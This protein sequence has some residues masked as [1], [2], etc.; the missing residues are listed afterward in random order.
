MSIIVSS[1]DIKTLERLRVI[2]QIAPMREKMRSFERKYGCE[3]QEFE[4]SIKLRPESFEAW[5]DL[6]EWKAYDQALKDLE[7]KLKRIEDAVNVGIAP[8]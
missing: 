3:F 6:I 1:E 5:D 7:L 8:G 4:E 2:S